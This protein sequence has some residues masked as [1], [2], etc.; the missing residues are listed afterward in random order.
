MTAGAGADICPLKGKGRHGFLERE[1]GYKQIDMAE[2]IRGKGILG[3]R[4]CVRKDTAVKK[5][6]GCKTGYSQW[7]LQGNSRKPRRLGAPD[8]GKAG[9]S[10]TSGT[11]T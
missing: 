9:N 6:S 10:K 8:S 7:H 4:S 1:A 11:I 3:R 5:L 2:G